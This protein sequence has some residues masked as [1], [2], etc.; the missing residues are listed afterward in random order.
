MLQ[1][2]KEGAALAV[3]MGE[4]AC[5]RRF[6]GAAAEQIASQPSQQRYEPCRFARRHRHRIPP[7]PT[8]AADCAL[9]ST[10]WRAQRGAGTFFAVVE[11]A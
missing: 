2:G 3:L 6:L 4:A 10:R 11:R 1:R 9:F 5:R 8:G 7:R